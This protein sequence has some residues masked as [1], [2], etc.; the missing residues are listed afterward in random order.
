MRVSVRVM[1]L[2]LAIFVFASVTLVDARVQ[3]RGPKDDA[4][5]RGPGNDNGR[6]PADRDDGPG[7]GPP[8]HDD[9]DGPRGPPGHDDDG[10]GKGPGKNGPG[11]DGPGPRPGPPGPPPK[12]STSS[13]T[14]ST[15]RS[16][17][18]SS[19]T[20][21]STT[22][23]ASTS[24]TRQP[25]TSSTTSSTR[26]STTSSTSKPSTSSTTSSTV[27]PTTSST[28]RPTTSSTSSTSSTT[29]STVRPTTSSTSSTSSTTSTTRQPTTS[30]TTS[31]TS[32]YTRNTYSDP[33]HTS[34]DEGYVAPNGWDEQIDGCG[35]NTRNFRPY[36]DFLA[37]AYPG[38]TNWDATD[39]N[40]IMTARLTDS[41]KC[42]MTLT[43]WNL[44]PGKQ[45]TYRVA[46]GG[47]PSVA[48]W[49]CYS[50]PTWWT[51]NG[52]NCT[53]V[54]PNGP[55]TFRFVS[56][57]SYYVSVTNGVYVAPAPTTSSLPSTTSSTTSS[58]Y[59]VNTYSDPAH[60][61]G[62]EGYVAPNGWD[63]KVD[64]CGYNTRNF[65]PYGDFLADAY[66]GATNWDATDPNT[67]M[68]ARLTDSTKC[69]MTLTVWNLIPGKQ[70]TY[71]V[72]AGGSPSVAVWGCYPDPTWWTGNGPNCTFV[73][74]NGPVTFRFVS[75]GSYYV[76]VTNG[77]YVAPAPTT[78]SLPSTSSIPPTTSTVAQSTSYPT[79]ADEGYVAANG[80]PD[81]C[82]Y[83]TRNWRV[84]GDFLSDAFPG[85]TNWDPANS[86][87][88]MKAQLRSGVTCLMALTV[89]GLVPGKFYQWK[90][91]I[92]GSP[93]VGNYGCYSDP[94]WY[95]GNGDPCSFQAPPSGAVTFGIVAS[96]SYPLSLTNYT[97]PATTSLPHPTG[98]EGYVAP[99]G[100]DEA[101]Y[102]CGYT[103][104]NFR[105]Y[106]DFQA[107]AFP[108]SIDWDPRDA[109]TIMTARLN[110]TAKCLLSITINNLVPGTFYSWKVAAGGDPSVGNWGCPSDSTWYTGGANPCTFTAPASGTVTL[111]IVT[112]D[113]FPLA[114][115]LEYPLA[116][117][118][119][120]P[121]R[122]TIDQSPQA[123][124]VVA[125]YMMGLTY[126]FTQSNF[127]SDIAAALKVGLD[128][129]ALNV[130]ADTWGADRVAAAFAA[131][132]KYPGFKL[133]F[134][135]DMSAMAGR[136]DLLTYYVNTYFNHPSSFFY[137]GAYF[138]ST[139][140]GESDNLGRG[141]GVSVNDAWLAW[142]TETECQTGRLIWFVPSWT[143]L[144][145][146]NLF[147]NYSVLDGHFAWAAWPQGSEDINEDREL[148][149]K[150][151]ALSHNKTY[152]ASVS[153]W[154]YTRLP[155]YNKNWYFKSETLYPQRWQEILDLQPD[156]V[157]V[158]TWNDYGE[159]HYIGPIN[160]A[161]VDGAAPYVQGFDH[162]GWQDMT[163]YFSNWYR[164]GVQPQVT[165]DRVTYWYRPTSK[166]AV[167]NDTAGLP[168]GWDN[169]EDVVTVFTVLS[170][171]AQ[172]TVLI[173]DATFGPVVVPAGTSYQTFPFTINGGGVT[174]L[175]GR[176]D[177]IIWAKG[178]GPTIGQSYPTY[179]FNA[180]VG[181]FD[182]PIAY[183]P[184]SAYNGH[185]SVD[186]PLA[187]P[188]QQACFAACAN[189]TDCVGFQYNSCSSQ[190]YIKTGLSVPSGDSCTSFSSN[191]GTF[192]ITYNA[193]D[194]PNMPVVLD[195]S[196]TVHA[197]AALCS[198][199][200]GCRAWRY[201]PNNQNCGTPADGSLC[202]LH[203]FL[204]GGF[205]YNTCF[206][207]GMSG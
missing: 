137:R 163:S 125:H 130:G 186:S 181:H 179:N 121:P 50:D 43:V 44:I 127:E 107:D 180:W 67:I 207:G 152:M 169:A 156:I 81:S 110:S 76:S 39:P 12:P 122:S 162:Q 21:P 178:D 73:A 118:C 183:G 129:F 16:T 136:W 164:S 190:C 161:I 77:V 86:N 202:Y 203:A 155:Q 141:F 96:D 3:K 94:S 25:T 11:K 42:L 112:K 68:T 35:Y 90:V 175:L 1:L 139:F 123:K 84:Y 78:S 160:A 166:Y 6:G 45:Y 65:R 153:P 144:G 188:N 147:D 170:S 37:D 52:P 151:G 145:P 7:R 17:T 79:H 34:G 61:S 71:R 38:A 134:S 89:T 10:P 36:G 95:T 75:G 194:L 120:A 106:G 66:P 64:G 132:A 19:T 4:P 51:G 80:W 195:G 103:T 182:V 204:T 57:G 27:R 23:K 74:P 9:D 115:V 135:F 62:D 5:P 18:T 60:T 100:W 158:I 47:S 131:A 28:V 31:S 108:G 159:S 58:T 53:F 2:V 13:T 116:G 191:L 98:D 150:A 167:V 157:E 113:L 72:A 206:V 189:R 126:S 133:F 142:K 165:A 124:K 54:A 93:T 82:G 69:L 26:Q 168:D 148:P 32:T 33:A 138:V 184:G 83:T 20:K 185:D 205:T 117:T 109:N 172:L 193:V 111:Q 40:T 46:A 173:G 187:K 104:R 176:D 174:I 119:K 70:Y 30:S 87:A 8:G 49:G 143:A 146:N 192:G 41:T 140:A 56:G 29:S 63:E 97:V 88:I 201:V 48:V 15:S 114:S 85:S 154:F 22:S 128:G 171:P 92:G 91:D 198:S 177:N 101:L 59:T 105:V 200:A 99:N 196:E 102:G 199:T 197:C 149:Y 55:V 24:T 14:K